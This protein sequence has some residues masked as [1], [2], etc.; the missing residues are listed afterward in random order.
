MN[1]LNDISDQSAAITILSHLLI[2][3]FK[4]TDKNI[5][6]DGM[7]NITEK[8]TSSKGVNGPTGVCK[9]PKFSIEEGVIESKKSAYT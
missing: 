1:N 9:L 4:N 2:L 5:M 3:G 8:I 6:D 7:I